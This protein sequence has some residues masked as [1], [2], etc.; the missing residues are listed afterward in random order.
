VRDV[1]GG[2][3]IGFM[4]LSEFALVCFTINVLALQRR[5]DLLV[6]DDGE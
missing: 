6:P 1:T 4:L 2:Y 5:A 3:A